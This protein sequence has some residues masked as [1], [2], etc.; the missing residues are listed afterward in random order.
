MPFAACVDQQA[1]DCWQADSCPQIE[2]DGSVIS[3]AKI[4]FSSPG[5]GKGCREMKPSQMNKVSHKNALNTLRLAM[6][7][8]KRERYGML[9]VDAADLF[10]S[11]VLKKKRCSAFAL[12]FSA[13]RQRMRVS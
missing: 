5:L 8:D 3:R 12:R 13:Y 7:A 9:L 6:A 10:R 2:S 1:G 11:D 4:S